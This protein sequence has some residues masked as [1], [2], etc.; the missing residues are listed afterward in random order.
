MWKWKKIK[1]Y[2]NTYRLSEYKTHPQ[3]PMKNEGEGGP[4]VV[5]TRGIVSKSLEKGIG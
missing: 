3:N 4:I 5:G 2:T 1:Q